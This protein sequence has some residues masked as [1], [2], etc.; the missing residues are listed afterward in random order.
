MIR[1]IGRVG[2]AAAILLIPHAVWGQLTPAEK[3]PWVGD[4]PATPPPLATD[5]SPA[6]TRKNVPFVFVTG[7]GQESLPRSFSTAPM[8]AKPFSREQLLRAVAPLIEPSAATLR[9]RPRA[10]KL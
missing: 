6:L 7:Y 4:T 8:L 2:L 3:V 1:V 10:P 9:L 5:L